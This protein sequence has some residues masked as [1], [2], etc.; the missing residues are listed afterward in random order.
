M[1][2]VLNLDPNVDIPD[3]HQNNEK[4]SEFMKPYMDKSGDY[5]FYKSHIFDNPNIHSDK[6]ISI[7]RHPLDVFL[8][9]LNY[10]NLHNDHDK[11][12]NG[13]VKSVDDIVA[14][15]ELEHYFSVFCNNLGSDYFS[16]MLGEYSNYELYIRNALS[17]E[18]VVPVKYEDIYDHPVETVTKLLS[19]I[20]LSSIEVKDSDFEHVND[21][22]K[23]SKNPF[24][25]KSKKNNFIDF[26]T[27]EQVDRFFKINP[28]FRT[29]G[30]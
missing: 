21:V 29:L 8:S 28:Y 12:I 11:F 3:I 19:S 15:D 10:F 26:F 9:S 27:K 7:Y 5:L 2:Q 1:G 22:T 20:G 14:D 13:V 17:A 4:T 16:G 23:N 30:Y 18:N 6:I 24:F 25:W